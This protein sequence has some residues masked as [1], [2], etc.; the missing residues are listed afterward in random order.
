MIRKPPIKAQETAPIRLNPDSVSGEH[1]AEDA[2]MTTPARSQAGRGGNVPPDESR[3]QPGESGNPKGRP[4]G[5]A[6]SFEKVLEQEL[7]QL[8]DGDPVLDDGRITRRRRLVRAL[9]G[10]V[11]R[12]DPWAVRLAFE[13]IWP[14]LER[15][16]PES[17][18]QFVFL[19]EQ[20]R[21]A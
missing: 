14:I 7:D 12:G 16:R 11:E 2:T 15:E 6:T 4:K 13:R 5:A 20:D 21:D 10:A 3:W 19:D 18:V 1:Q 17:Q 9:L 8:V